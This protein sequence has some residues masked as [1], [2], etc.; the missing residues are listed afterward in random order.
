MSDH[1]PR[2]DAFKAI[3]AEST[4]PLTRLSRVIGSLFFGV[5]IGA[6]LAVPPL[7]K[8]INRP[9]TSMKAYKVERT[10]WISAGLFVVGFSCGSIYCYRRE[11]K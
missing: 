5:L 11:G 9:A 1:L 2:L 8:A 3:E 10:K 7:W 4:P 6:I